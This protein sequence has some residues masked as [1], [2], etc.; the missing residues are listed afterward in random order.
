ML[1]A[2]VVALAA[3]VVLRFLSTSVMWLDESQTVAI[4]HRSLPDLFSALRVDGS[5]PLFYLLLHFWMDVVGTG[6]FAVRALSGIISVAAL[7]L[8]PVAA[9][10]LGL[11][12]GASWIALL[13]LATCP[14]AIRY[15]TEARMYSLVLLLCLLGII[16]FER[17][18]RDGSFWWI[19]AAAAVT[20]GLLL[21][22]Y[23]SLFLYAV[24]FALAIVLSLRGSHPARRVLVAL[25]LGAVPFIPW[26]P[27]FV[28]Q[29]LHTGAPWGSPPSIDTPL[30]TPSQ[31]SGFGTFGTL[32]SIA[33][34]LLLV[35][36]LVGH[37]RS[38]GDDSV[39]GD[40]E[41]FGVGRPVRRLPALLLGISGA[42][43]LAGSLVGMVLGSAYADRYST[44]AL[45]PALIAVAIGLTALPARWL[46][47]AV[48][49]VCA[50]GL[51][52]SIAL[53]FGQRTQAK[54]VANHLAVAA[55]GD[56][57]V[58]CPDQL[59]PAVHRLLPTTGRQVVYPTLGS[60]DI[61]NWVDY[62]DRIKSSHPDKVARSIEA[63]AGD[64]RIWLVFATDYPLFG[65][66]CTKLL[67][68]LSAARGAPRLLVKAHPSLLEHESLAEFPA[69]P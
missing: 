56:V 35:V 8:M 64:N 46:V 13:L 36:A 57:V 42:A 9:R 67:T 1:I 26:A 34:Y 48:T 66:H 69:K 2:A 6:T 22:H 68:D 16:A 52:A 25:A 61:V 37:S 7:A 60:P 40:R 54:Q 31:W 33:Y 65:S 53:P 20:A 32:L 19:V 43:L 24:T 51:I 41:W 14:F 44:M 30:L 3:A 49:V 23:W 28:F 47:P 59:G 55:P 38:P 17:V 50:C 11:S 21:T 39:D 15:A 63:M 58:F 18:W 4:S 62:A 29:M 10:R 27:T 45:A 5:P 12:R